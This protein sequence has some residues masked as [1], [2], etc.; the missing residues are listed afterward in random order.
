MAVAVTASAERGWSAPDTL[1]P[2]RVDPARQRGL[3]RSRKLG[4]MPDVAPTPMPGPVDAVLLLALLTRVRAG[5]VAAGELSARRL[6]DVRVFKTAYAELGYVRRLAAAG[7][8]GGTVLT[9]MRQLVAG[10]ARIHPAWDMTGDA[11]QARDRHY[12]AVRR[13]IRDLQEMGLIDC[14]IGHDLDGEERRTEIELKPAPQAAPQELAAAAATLTRWQNRYGPAL[15]TGSRTGIRNA[16]RHGRPLTASERQRRGCH[17]ARQAAAARRSRR[18]RSNS[19]PPSGASAA[20]RKGSLSDNSKPLS[21]PSGSSRTGVTRTSTP[22]PRA[23]HEATDPARTAHTQQSVPVSERHPAPQGAAGGQRAAAAEVP[24]DPEALV[25]RVKARQAERAPLIAAIAR[26][27][28][29][30]AVEVAAWTL[31]REWP[32]GRLREAWVVAR[33][34]ATTA[35]DSGPAAA[36]PLERE[37]YVQLRRAVARWERNSQA[38]PEGWPAGGLAALLH[39]GTLAAAGEITDP[40]RL[41]RYAI[42]RLDQL[43]KRLRAHNTATSAQRLNS[44]AARACRR[45]QPPAAPLFQYRATWPAW[46]LLPGHTEPAFD[47]CGRL[48]LNE[49]HIAAG[50]IPLADGDTY[51][52]AIRDA[53]LLARRP[54]PVEA[55][56]RTVMSLRD[57]GQI[58]CAGKPVPPSVEEIEL[59][60]LA[61]RTGEPMRLLR[62]LS[63][64]YRAA[65][66]AELRRR[67]VDQAR[68]ELAAFRAT[69]AGL[70]DF[71]R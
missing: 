67:D 49:R 3:K 66:L 14:R 45:R 59:R 57:R 50:W 60:E 11:F 5:R 68:R 43:S 25:A 61:H 37:R 10:L 1:A 32:P 17:H 33:Y 8:H 47:E 13:R 6:H 15:N 42:G 71:R 56:G 21:D 64:A 41:L 46:I 55:D 2:G 24:W 62:G 16:A 69:L 39:I 12:Q 70:G 26:Q 40:P 27:A 63:P 4:P 22:A 28:H 53:H 44:A 31:E 54:L 20:L 36:G 23:A 38:R 34:G 52:L 35:A 48:Q 58:E 19:P 7:R 9:S 65:W 51:R 29:A 30:R 18:F